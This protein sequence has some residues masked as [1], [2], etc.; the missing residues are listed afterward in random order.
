MH[1]SQVLVL[2]ALASSVLPQR[3]LCAASGAPPGGVVHAS[4]F[5]ASDSAAFDELGAALALAERAGEQRL[6]L[7]APRHA[8]A[9]V[10]S[11]AAYVFARAGDAWVEEAE[12]VAPDAQADDSCG[13]ALALDA[14]TGTWL[15][16][17][18]VPFDDERGDGSGSV[19]LFRFEGGA[20][21]HEAKLLAPEG[22]A[23]DRF[24]GALA[25]C[26][27]TLA[28]GARQADLAGAESG[29]VWVFRR[30]GTSWSLEARLEAPDAASGDLF[31][32][33][34]ALT[35]EG[36]LLAV[37][38]P[39]DDDLG[40]GSGSVHVFARAGT[41]WTHARKLVRAS[42]AA[43]DA[44]GSALA[45]V[46]LEPTALLGPTALLLAGA[47]GVDA[48]APEGGA[49]HVFFLH[50]GTWS[51]EARLLPA[52]PE[53]A[54]RFGSSLAL[55]ADAKG[56]RACVGAPQAAALAVQSGAAHAFVREGTSWRELERLLAPA[57]GS[58]DRAGS[59]VAL[60][61]GDDILVGSRPDS[62]AGPDPGAVDAWR[63]SALVHEACGG[64]AA[65]CPCANGGATGH[66][67]A[68]AQGVG[69]RLSLVEHAP[70]VSGGSGGG[71]A[72]FVA[73]GFP[74][75][76]SP[77]VVLFRGTSARTPPAP[78]GD[79]LLCVAAPLVR[80][81]STSASSGAASHALV[82][83]A[84]AGSFLYQ[85]WFRLGA[86]AC[87]ASFG[88]SNALELVWP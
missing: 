38:A 73:R 11:G 80:V 60:S 2:A 15:A 72:R 32:S 31:G 56:V 9:L 57:G 5:A 30:A 1:A 70:A 43:G 82:H 39:F 19:E 6:L 55:V 48:L 18:G 36:A 76:A 66:G 13:E 21:L 20:W 63:W 52:D 78:F 3:A 28:V 37:G 47:P 65:L 45:L 25:L 35:A 64:D 53:P 40:A 81:S 75:A 26:A 61:A 34:L 4:R 87:G 7:G 85:A 67:C 83:G 27:D 29:S 10:R 58:L 24:G 51:E 33:A 86:S 8:H 62:H 77:A 23:G 54:A 46:E 14:R 22:A 17:L 88:T 59:A 71:S 79:G 42:G 41:S 68:A 16:A 12:L 74:S 84:G 44:L 69:V 50:A 49:A